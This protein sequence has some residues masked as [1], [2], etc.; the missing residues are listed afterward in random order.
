[1]GGLVAYTPEPETQWKG[2]GKEERERRGK[3]EGGNRIE[4]SWEQRETDSRKSQ[5]LLLGDSLSSEELEHLLMKDVAR[6]SQVPGGRMEIEGRNP[7]SL[8][9][10]FWV[11][12]EVNIL[13]VLGT[14]HE[15]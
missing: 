11:N 8:H 2:G 6:T 5:S 12:M 1:M 13:G 7:P 10:G 14:M 3:R 15:G 9:R 4:G